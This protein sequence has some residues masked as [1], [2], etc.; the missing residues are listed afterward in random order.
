MKEDLEAILE[1]YRFEFP[2]EITRRSIIN[3]L[4]NYMESN[5]RNGIIHDF[6][7]IDKTYEFPPRQQLEF[8]V[9]YQ[10]SHI[11]NFIR[12]ILGI[13]PNHVRCTDSTGRLRMKQLVKYN[14]SKHKL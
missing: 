9:T 6:I 4:S 2:D 13:E 11:T 5:R 10:T 7:V 1:T 12:I 8:E 3:D 14:I